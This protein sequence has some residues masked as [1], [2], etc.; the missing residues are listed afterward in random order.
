MISSL[1]MIWWERW[2]RRVDTFARQRLPFPSIVRAAQLS[3]RA[4]RTMDGKS[5]RCS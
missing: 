4:A 5:R 2:A 1:L 3:H